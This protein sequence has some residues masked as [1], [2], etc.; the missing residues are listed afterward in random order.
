ML[1]GFA[2]QV[3]SNQASSSMTLK[4]PTQLQKNTISK[5]ENSRTSNDVA[6][7]KNNLMKAMGTSFGI[8]STVQEKE[9]GSTESEMRLQKA[10]EE[11][12]LSEKQ[13]AASKSKEMPS[14]K[15]KNLQQKKLPELTVKASD[16]VKS[17]ASFKEEPKLLSVEDFPPLDLSERSEDLLPSP[18]KAASS[19][20]TQEVFFEKRSPRFNHVPENN[21]LQSPALKKKL[22][23]WPERLIGHLKPIV[24]VEKISFKNMTLAVSI[25]SDSLVKLW[26]ITTSANEDLSDDGQSPIAPLLTLRGH[27]AP[28]VKLNIKNI[29]SASVEFLSQDEANV[30]CL[31]KIDNIYQLSP[32]MPYSKKKNFLVS[33][34][35]VLSSR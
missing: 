26:D 29:G 23:P 20:E 17:P 32:Y 24:H 11:E 19:Q 16:Q 27:S 18:T 9:E 12:M 5:V 6:E 4:R 2:S 14:G 33:S 28:L 30:C 25:S 7:P 34:F 1:G 22:I 21:E 8:P 3:T 10:I 35:P 31:W 15:S 13:A